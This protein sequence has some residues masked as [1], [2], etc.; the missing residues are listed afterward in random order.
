MIF[1]EVVH[2]MRPL[3]REFERLGIAYYV[4]GSVASSV[5]GVPRTTLDADVVAVLRINDVGP[6]VAGL[7]KEFY[8]SS[9]AARAAVQHQSSFNV[10]HLATT[11]K[12]DVFVVTTHPFDHSALARK[13]KDTIGEV[14]KLDV[15]LASPED[16][17]LHKLKWYRDGN[18][19]SDRQWGDILGL[20][21][22][23]HETLDSDYLQ[24]WAIELGVAD[25]LERAVEESGIE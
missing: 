2:A 5:Y 3:V 13:R 24:H 10:I 19:V 6:L 12:I 16:V 22:V 14:S 15:F 8:V 21:K 23:Q 9:D 4:G 11:F 25:L 7:A 18:E 1:G 17:L 20:L